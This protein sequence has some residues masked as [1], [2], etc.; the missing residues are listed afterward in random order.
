[1]QA[2]PG[3]P[4]PGGNL[5]SARSRPATHH[6]RHEAFS[7]DP[8]FAMISLSLDEKRDDVRYVVKSRKLSWP[9]A[10]YRVRVVGRD[11]VSCY[12]D[13]RDPPHRSRRHGPGPGP[14]GNEAEN[15]DRRDAEPVSLRREAT[16]KQSGSIANAMCNFSP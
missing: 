7:K 14:E 16:P 12:R 3:D 13:P 1:M 9:H 15:G 6:R 2:S 4:S 11:L 5:A 10:L 8:R